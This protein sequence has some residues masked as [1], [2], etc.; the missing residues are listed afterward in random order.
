M[1]HSCVI[2]ALNGLVLWDVDGSEFL[3]GQEFS[4]TEKCYFYFDNP[5]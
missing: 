3:Q 2:T 5:Y 1:K 4:V